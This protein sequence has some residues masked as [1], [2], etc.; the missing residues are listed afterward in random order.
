MILDDGL[1]AMPPLGLGVTPDEEVA[2]P[3]Q[4]RGRRAKAPATAPTATTPADAPEATEAGPADSSEAAE[5]TTD[6]ATDTTT[7]ETE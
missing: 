5:T 3:D 2:A 4:G 6:T 1:N 7:E